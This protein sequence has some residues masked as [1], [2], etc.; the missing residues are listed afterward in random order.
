MHNKLLITD[1]SN[2]IFGGRNIGDEHFGLADTLNL[3]DFDVMLT[4]DTLP[5]FSAVF[6][7][8]WTSASATATNRDPGSVDRSDLTSTRSRI[9][10][11]LMNQ[12]DKVGAATP[13]QNEWDQRARTLAR[14]L[15]DGSVSV[16]ADNPAAPTGDQSTH[17]GEA[18]RATADSARHD[19]VVATPFLVPSKSDISWYREIIAR[20]VR[21]RVLTNSLATNPG[22]VSNSGLDPYRMAM[23]QAGVELHE[24]RDDAATKADWECAP[25]I[26]RSLGLHAKAYVI[27]R[28]KTF[29]GSV[30]LD[31]RS[32]LINTEMGV[33]IDDAAL[34]EQCTDAIIRLTELDNAWR[35][36]MTHEGRLQWRNDSEVTR[37]QPARNLRQ[38][39]ADRAFRALPIQQQI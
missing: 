31:P 29:L 28:A 18:L 5:E 16:V 37:R 17:V 3:I 20:G 2:A 6:D 9:E 19:L 25:G 21:V 38:R 13:G 36:E 39:L 10:H 12:A 33:L 15:D 22:T 11:E 30:N 8:Y 27:D 26:G 14:P 32:K 4:A 34:A 24:L 7:A 1:G 23:L 35:V